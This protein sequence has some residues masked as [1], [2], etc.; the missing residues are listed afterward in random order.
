MIGHGTDSHTFCLEGREFA[1]A[2]RGS[3]WATV[4]VGVGHHEHPVIPVLPR[5][6]HHGA[7]M[8]EHRW[9]DGSLDGRETCVHTVRAIVRDVF[10]GRQT[11]GADNLLASVLEIERPTRARPTQSRGSGTDGKEPDIPQ[12]VS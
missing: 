9:L 12:W 1:Y 8:E 5:D 6:H 10:V 2:I 4:E 11:G 3:Q 7:V